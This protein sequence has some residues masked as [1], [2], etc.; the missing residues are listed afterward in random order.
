MI[1]AGADPGVDFDW[2]FW[3]F[4]QTLRDAAGGT[5]A[6]LLI[7]SVVLMAVALVV[8]GAGKISGGRSMQQVGGGALLVTALVSIGLGAANAYA[9]WGSGVDLG[10]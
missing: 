3:P 8:W 1:T 7:V 9:R 4:M 6:L 10:F 2:G 5:L